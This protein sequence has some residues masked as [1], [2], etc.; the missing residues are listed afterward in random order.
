VAP[1]LVGEGDTDHRLKSVPQ[2]AEDLVGEDAKLGLRKPAKPRGIKKVS[3]DTTHTLRS[4]VRTDVPIPQPPFFGSRVVQ[5]IPIEN[6]FDYVNETA[7]FKGQWQFK[8]GRTSAEEYQALVAEKIRPVYEELKEHCE[9]DG[10]LVPRVVYGYFPAQSAGNDLIVY[11][12]DATTERAR[13]TFPRQP[14]GKRLCLTD[15]FA[16]VDSG[17]MDVV[18]FDL[19]TVGRRAS[20]Y[21]QELFKRDSYADYLYFHGL[22]V[23]SAEALAEYWHKHIRQELGIADQD[24]K[25][26]NEL[27]RQGYQ[28]SR[29]S[30]GYPACPNL[31]DQVKLFELL[32]PSRIDVELTEEFQLEPEQ[33]TSAIVIHHPEAR[34]FSIE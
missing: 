14:A 20:E 31:E 34:Y 7:L 9:R 3:G 33:S 17:H 18:A 4:D 23:E 8:Q 24:A 5:D 6:V 32:D 27:F 10:L 19:V 22:S 26:L 13:F 15:Y 28:G 2:D 11:D 21:S 29:F 1:T 16:S 12:T 25:N 30:F